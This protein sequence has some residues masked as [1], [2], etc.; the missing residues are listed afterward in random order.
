M[1]AAAR[2]RFQLQQQ[3]A[4][5]CKERSYSGLVCFVPLLGTVAAILV[6][7][8]APEVSA[9]LASLLGMV[10]PPGTEGLV[11][12][13]FAASGG[14]ACCPAGKRGAAFVVGGI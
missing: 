6:Q 10:V 12:F 9:L 13:Q 8:K 5:L 1:A 2:I 3:R 4:A 11:S 7:V 14:T